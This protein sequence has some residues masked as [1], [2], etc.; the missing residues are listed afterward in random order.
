MS[1]QKNHDDDALHEV[2][3]TAD[4]LRAA[5]ALRAAL[6]QRTPAWSRGANLGD[7]GLLDVALRARAALGHA[8]PL[9]A[10]VRAASVEAALRGAAPR[11][12]SGRA[13]PWLAVAAALLV[14]ASGAALAVRFVGAATNPVAE[15]ALPDEAYARPTD[16]LFGAGLAPEQRASA[17]LDAIVSSR[18]RG[19][20]TGVA[21]ELAAA[22][23]G[24]AK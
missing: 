3:P 23:E 18:T 19:Y 13:G 17:R 7:E 10:A 15:R 14:A 20:F 6:E 5:E 2:E 12:S 22:Q 4:E 1:E 8:P 24:T 21:A 16:A 9:D 11:R